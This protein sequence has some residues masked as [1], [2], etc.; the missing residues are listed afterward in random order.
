MK[1]FL[2]SLLIALLPC[3]VFAQAPHKSLF[4]SETERARI[5]SLAA[6]SPAA[7]LLSAIETRVKLRAKTPGLMDETATSPWWYHAGEYLT[8]AAFIHAVR[9]APETD[10]WLRAVV[11]DIARRPLAEWAGPPFRGF[12]GKELVGSLETA[13]LT[14]AIAIAYDLAS[15]LFTPAEREEIISNL[16]EKGMVSCRRYLDRTD[17]CHNWNCVL[18]AGYSVAASVLDDKDALAY[19]EKW[20]PLAADHFQ[21]DGSY[22]ESLQYANYA[23]YSLMLAHEAMLRRAPENPLTFLPYAKMVDWSANAIFFRQPLAGLGNTAWPRT[24]NFGDS[25]A[26]FRPSGDLLMH[27]AARTKKEL[28]TQAGLARWLFDTHYFPVNTEGP[29]DLASFGFINDF[30]FLSVILFDEAAPAISPVAAK[31]PTT[32]A[33]S[34]GDAFARDSWDG[35][36]TLAARLPSAPRHATAHIHGDI[37][38]FILVHN[39]EE[40]LVDPGHSC[41]RNLIRELD[42]STASHNT[43]TFEIPATVTEPA[44]TLVQRG[45][46]NRPILREGDSLRGGDPIDSGGKRLITARVRNV[47]VIGADAAQLYGAPLKN[48]SRFWILCGS[49]ALFI[50]DQIESDVPVK[51]T[52]NFLFNNRDGQLDLKMERPNKI[53]A[54]LGD[55][56][57]TVN[58]FGGGGMSGPTYSFVHDYYHPLPAQRGEGRPSSGRMMRWTESAATTNR[59]LI[60]ALAVDDR[61][62]IP[63]WT[64]KREGNTYALTNAD[65]K[66]EWTLHTADDGTFLIEETI[67]R[68]TFT[69]VRDAAGVWSLNSTTTKSK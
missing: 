29:H 51:T 52:W 45:G 14:W 9:P 47:S 61:A 17:F 53:I 67:S 54:R 48:F 4:L 20:F 64:A 46:S 22:G 6:D 26:I 36:T 7:A 37:N 33:F 19:S 55:A 40:L 16:R 57:V 18:L 60:H 11:L 31:F 49:H 39:R 41:Y 10:A 3:A 43:C 59:T 12:T 1:F 5:R 68:E 34:G 28:P 66:E 62:S 27:I 21:T 50:V 25:A 63:N 2:T 69:V 44:R 30:G 42:T 13:H 8:D 23:A 56:G 65:R 35:L 15:D 38:S 32:V 58:H 24:A